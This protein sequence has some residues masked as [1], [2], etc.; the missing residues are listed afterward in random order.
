MHT[1]K[2]ATIAYKVLCFI[3]L[4]AMIMYWAYKYIKDED[5]CLV[6]YKSFKD[7]RNEENL[8]TLTI[9]FHTPFIEENFPKLESSTKEDSIT[10]STLYAEYLQGKGS[11]FSVQFANITYNDVCLLYTSDAADE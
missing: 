8:P 6:D 11:N 9:C 1:Y 3:A 10:T 5:L 7:D 2:L 4:I